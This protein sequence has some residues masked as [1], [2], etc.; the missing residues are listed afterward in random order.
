MSTCAC[1][2]RLLERL[3]QRELSAAHLFA[4]GVPLAPTLDEKQMLARHCLDELGHFEHVAAVAEEH[5]TSDLL[6]VISKRTGLL[7]IPSS[8]FEMVVVSISFDRAVYFQLRAYALAPD[9]R[10]AQLAV[11]IT[12]DE[13]EHLAAAQMALTD[14]VEREA[15]F[16]A[17][18]NRHI[19][20]WL[21]LALACFDGAEADDPACPSG[22][23]VSESANRQARSNY[24]SSLA[25]ALVPLGVPRARFT[26]S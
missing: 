21:P 11:R 1:I 13:Q 14:L 18:L 3:G 22:P 19:E 25:D 26:E 12:A 5:G 20:R 16:S 23:H 9:E 24:L 4:S 6:S 7:P 15:D 2:R 10:V 17:E 8:W